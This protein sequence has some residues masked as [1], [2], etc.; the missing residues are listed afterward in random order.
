LKTTEEDS[1]VYLKADF[2][3]WKMTIK[4][5]FLETKAHIEWAEGCLEEF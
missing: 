2:S 1:N 4:Y 5:S 3:F